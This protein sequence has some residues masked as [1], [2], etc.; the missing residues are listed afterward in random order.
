[1]T[2][3]FLYA[4][5]TVKM[6]SHMHSCTI[7]SILLNYVCSSWM[8]PYWNRQM[9]FLLEN[10]ICSFVLHFKTLVLWVHCLPVQ[11]LCIQF[12]KPYFFSLIWKI[13]ISI[14]LFGLAKIWLKM[15]TL[16]IEEKQEQLLLNTNLLQFG[17]KTQ[18]NNY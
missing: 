4:L 18:I 6:T 8:A 11:I 13:V 1:M 3:F 12:S 16:K 7:D 9:N 17:K 5:K 10:Q 2:Y 14:S 15:Y